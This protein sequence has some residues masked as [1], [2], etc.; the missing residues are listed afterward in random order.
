MKMLFE[1]FQFSAFQDVVGAVFAQNLTTLN[2]A[3]TAIDED[4]TGLATQTFG[5]I[6]TET[7]NDPITTEFADFDNPFEVFIDQV[8]VDALAVDI[9]AI[10]ALAGAEGAHLDVVVNNS[11][12][13][14]PA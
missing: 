9:L 6:Y 11:V 14:I 2:V 10:D 4:D 5:L 13:T 7:P 8:M 3:N 1:T 12:L